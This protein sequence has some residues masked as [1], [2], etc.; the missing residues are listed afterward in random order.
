MRWGWGGLAAV[1][2]AAPLLFQDPFYERMI[3]L[4]LLWAVLASAWNIVGGYAGQVSFGHAMFFGVG[5]Y[6]P[7]LVYTRW[8]GVPLLGIPVGVTVSI[9]IAVLVGMPTFRLHGHYLSMATIAACTHRGRKA[10]L[11]LLKPP[12]NRLVSTGASLKPALRRSTEV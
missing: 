11:R 2:L 8:H 6:V 10:G 12:G 1:L 3:A 5:A 9:A 7:L 4:M